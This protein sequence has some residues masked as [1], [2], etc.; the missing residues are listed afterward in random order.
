MNQSKLKKGFQTLTSNFADSK[1]TQDTRLYEL[2]LGVHLHGVPDA[3]YLG[4]R[5]VSKIS[6][7]IIHPFPSLS[8][9]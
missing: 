6:V 1:N 8:R 5:T 7:K 3:S 4:L 2:P 9:L